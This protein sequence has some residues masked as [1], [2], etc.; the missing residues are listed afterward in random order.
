M[1]NLPQRED[2]KKIIRGI[3][4]ALFVVLIGISVADM[5]I[6]SLTQKHE[7][8]KLM[9]L[10]RDPREGYSAYV[11]GKSYPLGGVLPLADIRYAGGELMLTTSAFEFRIPF[12]RSWDVA[13]YTGWLSVWGKQFVSEA[14][15][16][17]EALLAYISQICER[18]DEYKE[19]MLRLLRGESGK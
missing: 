5:Q 14:H 7:F 11:F 17:K 16:T 10:R 1:L 13:Q 18:A 2:R 6:N 15:R 8:G 12:R 4:A 19:E 3:L 9:N